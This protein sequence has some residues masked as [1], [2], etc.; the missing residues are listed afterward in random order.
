[1]FVYTKAVHIDIYWTKSVPFCSVWGLHLYLYVIIC[2]ALFSDNIDVLMWFLF[3][4]K[5]VL[6]WLAETAQYAW[7]LMSVWALN[8]RVHILNWSLKSWVLLPHPNILWNDQKRYM[9]LGG[10]G[11]WRVLELLL[12]NISYEVWIS[13]GA[14][15]LSWNHYYQRSSQMGKLSVEILDS[16]VNYLLQSAAR[17]M[18][19]SL[20]LLVFPPMLTR[21][22]FISCCWR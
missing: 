17:P 2:G 13:I 14:H 6:M 1:M 20:N 7:S 9:A 12:H 15:R 22:D 3:L 19:V 5:Y 8:G 16:V 10:A 21:F 4:D 18:Y 11:A